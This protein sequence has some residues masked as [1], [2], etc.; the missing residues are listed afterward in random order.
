MAIHLFCLFSFCSLQQWFLSW[1]RKVSMEGSSTRKLFRWLIT[2][3]SLDTKAACTR[4]P[5]SSPFYTLLHFTLLPVLVDS[6][7]FFFLCPPFPLPFCYSTFSCHPP[8]P[9][10]L[11]LWTHLCTT[12]PWS[13]SKLIHNEDACCLQGV[14]TH[15]FFRPANILAKHPDD[16][17]SAV[18][19]KVWFLEVAVPIS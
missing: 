10:S 17:G 15:L 16:E 1:G 6:S 19:L 12:T 9:F 18:N 4:P 2:W 14:E 3:G 7:F 5:S 13:T 8:A 11:S